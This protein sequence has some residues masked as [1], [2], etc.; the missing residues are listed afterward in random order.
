[1]GTPALPAAALSCAL[2]PHTAEF[3]F[4]LDANG[5]KTPPDRNDS[6]PGAQG[7]FFLRMSERKRR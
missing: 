3:R 4:R 7:E 1:M 5:D 2:A 6:D